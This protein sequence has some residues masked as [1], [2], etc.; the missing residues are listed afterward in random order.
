MNEHLNAFTKLEF[1]KVK[2]H[3][4]RYALSD[5]GREQL[6]NLTPSSSI[7]EVRYN[8]ALV[9]E[10]KHLLN[11]D[12]A[13]PLEHLLDIRSS[14]HRSSIENY[15]LTSQELH[16]IA[17]VLSTSRMVQAYFGRRKNKCK[18]LSE[19]FNTLYFNKIIEYNISQ[20][21]DDE[22]NVKDSASKELLRIRRKIENQKQSL[23]KNLELILK[24]VA[25]QDWVQDEIITTR[26]GRMVIPIK[27]EHKNRV[28]GFMHSS[29]ASGATVFIEP[30]ETLDL[31][32]DICTLHY[33]EQREITKV[34][35]QLTNQIREIK[36]SILLGLQNL[37][38]VDSL[39]AKAKYSI[40]LIANEPIISE[41][42][43][44]CI[45]A[46]YHP[47]LLQKHKRAE[48]IPL[49]LEIGTDINTIIISGPNAGGKSVAMKTVGL[50]SLLVQSGCHIPTSGT[51]E[52]RLFTDI[53]V[54]M[55]D[56]QSIEND[57]SSFSSHLRNINL[58]VENSNNSSLVLIDEIG[59]GTDPSEGSALAAA[60]L[61]YLSKRACTTIAT[62]HHGML[63]SF[64]FNTTRFVNAS[65]DFD[66]VSLKP[67][68]RF[69]LGVPGSSYAIEM[70]ERMLLPTEIIDRS[71]SFQGKD[72]M[73]L[74]NLIIDL[75]KKTQ[76]LD[77]N[78]EK[79][80][81]DK[82][83]Y[84]TL[85]LLYEDKVSYLN[86]ELRDIK[87]KAVSE[88]KY[89]I[90]HAHATIEKSIKQI[91]ERS[92]DKEIIKNARNE[93]KQLEKEFV[94][95]HEETISKNDENIE[96]RVGDIVS[97]KSSSSLGEVISKQGNNYF[98]LIGDLKIKA[99][100][101]ELIKSHNITA[102]HTRST[103]SSSFIRENIKPDLDLR[104]MYAEDAIKAIEKFF[105]EAIL[106]GFSRVNLIHGKGTG[107]LRRKIT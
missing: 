41:E 18:L 9:S 103:P 98:V 65:M 80:L 2:K 75:E 52:M 76:Q 20:A 45:K 74:E 106:S 49:N 24:R 32:N 82:E 77:I 28:P 84:L 8:L 14:L 89:I 30:T 56:E 51:S 73:M 95:L 3:I 100:K 70:A 33:E 58:I 11:E 71:K 44:F 91:K 92:A 36:D 81:Q 38:D 53:F 46:A 55:G 96:F 87:Y 85:K 94:Q 47:L 63:K 50:L 105:D 48:I 21:I 101:K 17:L 93:I 88:A 12:E 68:Y 39:Q 83:Q 1:D 60:V 35:S 54:D 19:K 67:T 22:G 34:L 69:K 26:D 59:S 25:G 66:L 61:E 10:M 104:G 31:N 42:G 40:E 72:R 37:T 7:Q 16:S 57:L 107:A 99:H 43:H 27:S 15:V 6:N 86:K 13:P 4:Q 79:V 5:L 102:M 78:L 23:R 29:S 64:A 62:T 97:M 90:D